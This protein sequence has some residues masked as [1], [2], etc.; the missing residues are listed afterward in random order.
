MTATATALES[1]DNFNHAPHGGRRFGISPQFERAK[2]AREPKPVQE[3]ANPIALPKTLDAVSPASTSS[4]EIRSYDD[5]IEHFRKRADELNISR[6]TLDHIAGL[7]DGLSGKVLGVS[8]TRRIG[9]TTLECFLDALA[10]RHV[11]TP[12]PD[13]LER[14]R[15]RCVARD[16]SHTASAKARWNATPGTPTRRSS[17]VRK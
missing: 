14:N 10:L 12:D 13:A 16:P 1:P 6:L 9:M 8:K 3:A 5:L 11:V 15:S 17:R 7:P 2:V 4:A